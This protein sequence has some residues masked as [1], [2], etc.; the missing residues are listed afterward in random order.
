[1]KEKAANSNPILA[2]ASEASWANWLRKNFDISQG[3]WLR[4]AKK[5]SGVKS[6]SFSDALDMALCYGW[7]TGQARGETESTWLSRFLP[8]SDGSIWS[9][10]NRDRAI[11]LIRK[12]KMKPAGLA[13][14]ERAKQNGQWEKAYD[15]P[16]TATVPPDLKKAL[17]AS[18]RANAFFKT[19][20]SANRYAILWRIQT[21]KKPEARVR[22]IQDCVAMLEKQKT[23]HPRRR[24]SRSSR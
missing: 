22:K 23:F 20:D 9:K 21:A 24:N 12:G 1:M 19:L 15:S 7:I 8:R 4:L 11:A 2:F 17:D 14:I 6:V 3:V 18:P 16:K 5:G 10:I 13:A